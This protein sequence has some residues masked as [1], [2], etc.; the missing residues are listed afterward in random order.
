MLARGRSALYGESNAQR[1]RLAPRKNLGT[2]NWMVL[3]ELVPSESVAVTVM[4]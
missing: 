4:T 1:N 3:L 2:T